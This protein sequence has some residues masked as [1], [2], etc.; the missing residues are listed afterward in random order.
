MLML[1]P[2]I[3]LGLA[4]C[5]AAENLTEGSNP[6]DVIVSLDGSSSLKTTE[7][8]SAD[9]IQKFTIPFGDDM[10]V[11]AT[12]QPTPEISKSTKAAV[13]SALDAGVK[14]RVVVY[15]SSGVVVKDMVCTYAPGTAVPITGLDVGA[16]YTFVVY[17]VNS[18][19]SVPTV[20]GT[21][22]SVAKLSSVSG[23]LMYF[24]TQ[25]TVSGSSATKISVTM[26]HMFS[27]IT[28]YFNAGSFGGI[29]NAVSAPTISPNRASADVKLADSS[30]VY[31]G[32]ATT[33]S[34]VLSS[35]LG[36]SSAVSSPTLLINP[37]T[38]TGSFSIPS[39]TVNNSTS[40]VNLSNVKI[41]PRY[42]YDLKMNFNIPCTQAVGTGMIDG[43]GF[44][45]PLT[46]MAPAAD[47]GFFFD[48]YYL[49]NSFNMK[50]NGTQLAV[51]ELQFEIPSN[52][53]DPL[54]QNVRFA[55]GSYW[56]DGTVPS[57]WTLNGSASAGK[58]IL[59]VVISKT[60]AISLY[61]SKASYNAA[62]YGLLPLTQRSD[63]WQ[64]FNTVTWNISGSN[65]VYI[66]QQQINVTKITGAGYGS[67]IITC[68]N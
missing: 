33:A 44:A 60:G 39:I 17:S 18:T 21:T 63:K 37:A 61:G 66:S 29:I 24:K 43:D 68:P 12:L 4:G 38:S 30:V 11:N 15:N 1:A 16:T 53:L 67:K 42:K 10:V 22:L 8:A 59:R 2:V 23:D 9:E 56:Q 26:Q 46:V 48:I 7:T 54:K 32:S 14:Y 20:T 6:G 51:K 35:G 45:K 49:D 62:G 47:Y 58:P 36:T 27:Q 34:V 40:S 55:D 65:T 41:N 64:S 13:M 31:N 5:S 19:S 3:A 57:I 28:S 25:A 52:F 50:I